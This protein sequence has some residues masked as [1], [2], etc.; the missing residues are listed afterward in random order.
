[1][2]L[3]KEYDLGVIDKTK[4]QNLI[5]EDLLH[6]LS[7]VSTMA[8]AANRVY[9]QGYNWVLWRCSFADFETSKSS[10]EDK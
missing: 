1:M 4:L 6:I 3:E 2:G 8:S 10:N 7:F 5:V 9:Y